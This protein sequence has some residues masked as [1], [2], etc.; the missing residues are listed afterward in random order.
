MGYETKP[1]T[2][3]LFTNDRK[4]QENHPDYNGKLLISRDLLQK[5][6]GYGEAQI[7]ISAWI[8]ETKSGKTI[9]NLSCKEPYKKE[10]SQYAPD[11]IHEPT[12]HQQ[13]AQV[14]PPTSQDAQRYLDKLKIS[15]AKIENYPQFEELYNKIHSPKVWEVFKANAA[16][17]QEATT[18]LSVKKGQLILATAPVDLSAIISKIDVEVE[19][20]KLPAKEHCLARWNKSRSQLSPEEL[21]IYL[22]ELA[23]AEPIKNDSDFF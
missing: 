19:R 20:L 11:E 4:A 12:A 10:A 2:G 16:I 14:A 21:E 5:L 22:A 23:I 6:A 1:N 18:I 8:K 3:T 15:I 7:E 17:A 13:P 9:I